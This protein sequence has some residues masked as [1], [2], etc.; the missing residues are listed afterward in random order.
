MSAVEFE[1]VFINSQSVRTAY[2]RTHMHAHMHTYIHHYTYTYIYIYSV[3]FVLVCALASQ[4]QT[5]AYN[6]PP[7]TTFLKTGLWS[8][9]HTSCLSKVTCLISSRQ[10]FQITPVFLYYK[11]NMEL[12][13]QNILFPFYIIWVWSTLYMPLYGILVLYYLYAQDTVLLY[14]STM[15]PENLATNC[16]VISKLELIVCT[17]SWCRLEC[18]YSSAYESYILH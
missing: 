1:S 6:N 18:V 14:C 7:C 12:L 15:T 11:M 13:L 5:V 17:P 2:R 3:N 8:V 4:Y 10:C 9:S 16:F